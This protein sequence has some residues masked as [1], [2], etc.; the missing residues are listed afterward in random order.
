MISN[1]ILQNTIDGLR[2]IARIDMCVLDTEGTILAATFTV[3]DDYRQHVRDFAASPA[4]SQAIQGY[5]FFKVYDEHQ[6]EYIVMARGES[7]DIYMI[8]KIAAFQLQNLLV[9]YQE[10]FDKDNFIKNLLLDNLL[11]VD[12]FNRAK[13]LHIDNEARR[14]VLIV[15]A[16]SD[17]ETRTTTTIPS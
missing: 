3:T 12:I 11:S 1:Q 15:D 16:E 10:R 17:P 14:V 4:D 5:Q 7:D 2:S 13:K 9:A 6:L 8:G